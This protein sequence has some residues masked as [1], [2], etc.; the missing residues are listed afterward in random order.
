MIFYK[1]NQ[2][3]KIAYGR[4]F[5]NLPF[6]ISTSSNISYKVEVYTYNQELEKQEKKKQISKQ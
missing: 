6:H 4:D 1:H 5:L 3:K 2:T